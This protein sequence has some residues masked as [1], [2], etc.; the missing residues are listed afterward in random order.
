[1]AIGILIASSV[2]T[3]CDGDTAPRAVRSATNP[4]GSSSAPSAS[5]ESSHPT[6]ATEDLDAELSVAFARFRDHPPSIHGTFEYRSEGETYFTYELWV[7]LPAFRLSLSIRE[8]EGPDAGETLQAIT[9]ATQDGKRFAVRDAPAKERYITRSFGEGVWVLGP[10]LEFLAPETSPLLCLDGHG[11]G[12]ESVLG[13]SAIVMR[14]TEYEAH[15]AWVYRETGLILRQVMADSSEEPDWLGFAELE[16][17]PDLD[18][19]LFVP[20]SV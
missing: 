12:T 6:P 1:M 14:C 17:E 4:H 11:I 9:V 7:D 20:E 13:R 15:D 2:T 10:M 5:E 8:R 3:A 19:G 16:F 18:P